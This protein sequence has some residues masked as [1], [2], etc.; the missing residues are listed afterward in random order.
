MSEPRFQ[1][2]EL[3]HSLQGEGSLTG[4]PSV[5]VRLA[6]CNLRCVWCDSTY[7]REPEAGRE[8]ALPEL[9]RQVCAFPTRFV[10]LTGG[11]PMTVAGVQALAAAL[12][13]RQRHV[14]IE[15]NGTLPPDKIACD[16][17]SISPKLRN[18][19]AAPDEDE[20]RR[21][22]LSALAAWVDAYDFQFKFV[23]SLPRDV[24]EA[25]AIL[26]GLSRPV[27]PERVLLMPEGVDRAQLRPRDAWLVEVC[28]AYGFRYCSRLQIEL[29]GA[30]AGV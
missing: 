1:V 25:R 18:S 7:A 27:P 5:F 20:T 3:F 16:L 30:R 4:V 26:A 14:T 21:I 29:F 22:N 28:K 9:V 24:L 6:G 15:T 19:S 23:V 2:V 11:E 12:R 10:V 13:E 17:A 8:L